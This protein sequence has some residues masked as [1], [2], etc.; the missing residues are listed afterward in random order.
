M[1]AVSTGMTSEILHHPFDS[2]LASTVYSFTISSLDFLF[3]RHTPARK[4][5]E[6]LWCLIVIKTLTDA[7]KGAQESLMLTIFT[8]FEELL[9]S[10]AL[11]WVE[12]ASFS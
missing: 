4:D 3:P 6:H 1:T 2:C 9:P 5:K 10:F 7:L 11:C 8:H 12:G